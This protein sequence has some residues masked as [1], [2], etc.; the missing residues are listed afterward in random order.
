MSIK[1]LLKHILPKK[2]VTKY[3]ISKMLGYRINLENP[4]TF[5]EKIQWLKL[6]Y[7]R[8]DLSVYAD[9]VAVRN[10]VAK[11]IGNKYLIP[12]HK[13]FNNYKD[14]NFKILPKS[15]ALKAAHGSKWNIICYD[16]NTLNK[17]QLK[18]DLKTW[19]NSNYYWLGYE[20]AY[21]KI[22]PR[23]IC[24]HLMLNENNQIPND[25]KIFCFNNEPKFIQVDTTRYTKHQRIFYDTNWNIQP[26]ELGFNPLSK[27]I[28]KPSSLEEMLLVAKKLSYGF[29]FV[30]IDLYEINNKIYFGEMTFYPGEGSERFN[31]SQWDRILGDLLILPD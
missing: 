13:V 1:Q 20:Y 24:E 31:P 23:F 8:K 22:P 3:R 18:K 29:P 26:F 2:H 19:G 25:Y 14:I 16:K 4:K 9:K 28:E 11:I 12:V 30:R 21:K 27:G 7:K 10:Y 15:F 17:L 5:N 6:N